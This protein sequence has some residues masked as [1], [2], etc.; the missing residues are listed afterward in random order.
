MASARDRE[1]PAAVCVAGVAIG[2]ILVGIGYDLGL[3]SI[4]LPGVAMIVLSVLGFIAI[5]WAPD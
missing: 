5:A 1:V 2:S 3:A 4:A